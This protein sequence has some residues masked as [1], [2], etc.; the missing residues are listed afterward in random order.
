[1]TDSQLKAARLPKNVAERIDTF[2]E[3]TERYNSRSDFAKHACIEKLE[4]EGW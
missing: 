2:V 4:Q 3:T 1:M